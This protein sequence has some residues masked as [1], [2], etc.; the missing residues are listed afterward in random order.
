MCSGRICHLS[1]W[2]MDIAQFALG[3]IVARTMTHDTILALGSLFG[4]LFIPTLVL[5]VLC[6]VLSLILSRMTGWDDMTCILATM[7]AGL[8]QVAPIA[9]EVGADVLKVALLHTVRL[10]SIVAILPWIIRLL[11]GQ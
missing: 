7:P 2:F 10:F 6:L 9:E 11:I 4:P 1:H 8:T 5:L 3:A